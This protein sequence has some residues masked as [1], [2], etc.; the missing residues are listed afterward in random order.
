MQYGSGVA[1]AVAIFSMALPLAAQNDADDRSESLA[2]N[3]GIV[4]AAGNTSSTIMNVGNRF[5][6]DPPESN[7]RFTQTFH[8]VKSAAS[9]AGSA[10][11]YRAQVRLDRGLGNQFYLFAVAG[12]ERNVPAGLRRRFEETI[13]LAYQAV[14]TGTDKLG[15]ESGVSFYQQSN[16][17]IGL[18]DP[19]DDQYIAG[20]VAGR[21][22]RSLIGAAFLL[23]EVEFLPNFEQTNDFRLNTETALVAPISRTIG[24][25]LGYTFRYDNMPGQAATPHEH[26]DRLHK[27][28]RLLTAGLRLTY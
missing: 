28:D 23:Q 14:A 5:V 12:W 4:N 24:L 25:K 19:I 7:I 26:G 11:N 27:S 1:A 17:D 21:Y 20:R 8:A 6:V 2:V 9:G 10:A 13:G 3:F 16:L 15:V 18:P 22:R